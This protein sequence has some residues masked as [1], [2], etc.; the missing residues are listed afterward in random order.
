M[1]IHMPDRT[2]LAVDPVAS[3]IQHAMVGGV[4]AL[5]PR[6]DLGGG[7]LAIVNRNAR[8]GD[9]PH[10]AETRPGPVGG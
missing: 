7:Q 8:P 10:Q 3:L 1:A 4:A 2:E 6:H 9:A 5:N